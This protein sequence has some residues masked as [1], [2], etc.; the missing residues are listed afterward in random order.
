MLKN[1]TE[2]PAASSPL[3]DA[4]ARRAQIRVIAAGLIDGPHMGHRFHIPAGVALQ[5]SSR[6][7]AHGARP[8]VVPVAVERPRRPRLRRVVIAAFLVV[9]AGLLGAFLGAPAFRVHKVEVTGDHL[10]SR[11]TVLAAARVPSSSLFTVDED[12]IRARLAELPWVRSATV[13]TQLP[14]TV[15][16]AVTEWQP[17]VLLRHGDSASFVAA[18]GATLAVTPSTR[19]TRAGIPVLLDYRPG[20]QRPLLAGL[21]DLLATS[22]ARW[23]AVFGCTVDAFVVSNSNVLSAWSSTGWQVVFGA[24]DSSDAVAAVP[25]QLAV[26]A[27]LEGRLNFRHPGFGYVDVENPS[28]PTVGGHPGE[29]ASVRS[30]LAGAALP[31]SSPVTAQLV[32]PSTPRPSPTATPAPTPPSSPTPLVFSLSPTPSTRR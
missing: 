18:D 12:A 4:A 8:R 16:I 3:D 7:R 30:A 10:L 32:A 9:Q 2:R 5:P 27:A 21:A 6:R 17:D 11:A 13:T 31:V 1:L 20:A 15:E 25:G 24:L 29:P 26:L 22:S 19:S 14:S 23:Q 28:T